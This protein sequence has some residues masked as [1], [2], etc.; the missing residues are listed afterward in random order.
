MS[1]LLE[2]EMM[3]EKPLVTGSLFFRDAVGGP[4]LPNGLKLMLVCG[5]IAVPD[6]FP[7]AAE[8]IATLRGFANRDSVEFHIDP[9]GK[10]I[11]SQYFGWSIESIITAPVWKV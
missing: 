8:N 5:V 4:K 11:G 3:G 2:L 6:N 1:R 10:P 9:V 7:V